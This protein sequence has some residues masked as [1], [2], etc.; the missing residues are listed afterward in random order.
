MEA[1]A[2]ADAVI[3]AISQPGNVNVNDLVLRP[4][5]QTR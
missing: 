3:Y 2:I 1:E 4:L 5:G